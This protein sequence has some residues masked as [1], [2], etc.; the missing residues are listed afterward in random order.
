MVITS[1]VVHHTTTRQQHTSNMKMFYFLLSLCALCS[2]ISA[3]RASNDARRFEV[4]DRFDRA[5]VESRSSPSISR[6]G[7]DGVPIG[8]DELN[9]AAMPSYEPIAEPSSLVSGLLVTRMASDSKSIDIY[10]INSKNLFF[11][12]PVAR[13]S[14]H[15]LRSK[16]T[17]IPVYVAVAEQEDDGLPSTKSVPRLI[18]LLDA[19]SSKAKDPSIVTA[20]LGSDEEI[21]EQIPQ[22]F[23]KNLRYIEAEKYPTKYT[24]EK[25]QPSKGVTYGSDNTEAMGL[26]PSSGSSSSSSASSVKMQDIEMMEK[27]QALLE[28]QQEQL[29]RYV[30]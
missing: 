26:V 17:R 21:E 28:K 20:Q 15:A 25:K 3:G 19:S 11:I 29:F 1:V 2:V 23:E 16:E 12:F 8:K 13:L 7:Y 24:E 4:Y 30:A 9:Y 27:I 5:M 18:H 6:V 10:V 22:F 14:Q